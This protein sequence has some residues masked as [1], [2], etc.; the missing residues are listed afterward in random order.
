MND[1]KYQMNPV[2]SSSPTKSSKTVLADI[3]KRGNNNF[4]FIRLVVAVAVIFGHSFYLFDTGGYSEPIT[5][6]VRKNFSGTLAVGVFSLS[7]EY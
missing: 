2:S 7:V 1:S 5:I 4:D 3:L 6:N